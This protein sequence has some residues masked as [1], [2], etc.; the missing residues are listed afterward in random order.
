MKTAFPALILLALAATA[1]EKKPTNTPAP[2]PPTKESS[3]PGEPGNDGPVIDLGAATLG[4]YSVQAA[5]GLAEIK[6]GGEAAIDVR[7]TGDGPKVTAVR[8]WIG[9]RDVASSIKAK[10]E[11]HDPKEPNHWHAHV[12]VPDPLPAGSSLWV[13]IE[14]DQGIKSVGG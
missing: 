9:T 11:I 10:A 6:A 7:V 3:I 13:E 12:E 2:T 4:P 8:F 5:R 14:N 1:C